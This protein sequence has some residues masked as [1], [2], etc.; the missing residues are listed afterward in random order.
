MRDWRVVSVPAIG[1]LLLLIAAGLLITWFQVDDCA[2]A[3]R[4]TDSL[5]FRDLHSSLI[6]ECAGYRER[7][8]AMKWASLLAV[9]A[10]V[11]LWWLPRW[12]GD[13]DV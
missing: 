2:E 6:L 10:M 7:Y 11:A 5:F 9:T 4:K 8:T 3:L 1:V 12:R 13:D